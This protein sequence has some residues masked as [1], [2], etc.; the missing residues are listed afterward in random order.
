MS[1][2]RKT[3]AAL[4]VAA[5]RG[6]RTRSELPKQYHMIGAA[7][8]LRHTLAAFANHPEID[9]ILTLIHP[10]DEKH[11]RRAAKNI[12]KCLPAIHGGAS[13]QQTV[14]I[15]LEALAATDAQIVLIHDAARPFVSPAIIS[16]VIAALARNK[17]AIAAMP[18]TDTLKRVQAD[19]ISGTCE[20]DGLWRAQ[21]PQAFYLP[22]ILAAHKNAAEKSENSFTDDAAVA[23]WAGMNVAVVAGEEA[24]SKITTAGDIVLANAKMSG[25]M[26]YK[27]GMGFDVHAFTDG[28]HIT[29]C[30]VDI[31]HSHGL[32]GHSDADVALHALTDA[33]LGAIAEDDIGA[34]FP[35]G[36]EKWAGAPSDRFAR[37][38]AE[39]VAK[40][41][42]NIINVDITIICQ[43][44]KIAPHRTA[45]RQRTADIL[46]IKLQQVSIKATTTEGLGFTGREEGIAAQAVA[47]ISTPAPNPDGR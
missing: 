38:A 40:N 41:G 30:G 31:P 46:G 6:T 20:R 25:Q 26:Q 39:Q 10:D 34:H 27:T 42:G 35:P 2:A 13:R 15:G 44:P 24:N 3:T 28:D 8:V 36:D 18:V 43:N 5:G 21:T 32:A 7:P 22:G 1:P 9:V 37:F 23:E 29:L 19:V 47:S 16:R 45:M 4:I 17:G 12:A 14:R 11:Y 33:I